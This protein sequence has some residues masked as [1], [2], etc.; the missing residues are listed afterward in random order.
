M[1]E[2]ND[3]RDSDERLQLLREQWPEYK[4]GALPINNVQAVMDVVESA[5][6]IKTDKVVVAF[7][8]QEIHMLR[9]QLSI[10]FSVQP[11]WYY[12]CIARG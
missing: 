6:F 10:R 8:K 5:A 2:Y 3:I 9:K 4:Q 12:D 1:S 7:F 11:F